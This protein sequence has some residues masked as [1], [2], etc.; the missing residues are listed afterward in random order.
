MLTIAIPDF[1]TLHLEHLVLDF[2]GTL[3]CDGE[4]LPG[5]RERLGSLAGDLRIHVVTADT[6]GTVERAMEGVPC[7]VTVLPA[8]D[9][10]RAK[11]EFVRG[12]AARHTVAV[13]NGRNDRLML[14][15]AALGF[16]VILEEGAAAVTLDAA[17][18]V[19]TSITGALDLLANPQRLMATL[20]S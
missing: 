4:L 3:A 9:Q 7:E 17:D 12:L 11:L 15:E 14:E 10:A 5:V 2:N 8:A 1:G 18:V 6:F 19:C 20:R 13:G 16:A